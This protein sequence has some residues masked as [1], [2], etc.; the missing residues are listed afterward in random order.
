MVRRYR[1][2]AGV[3]EGIGPN[4]YL[5]SLALFR[6]LLSEYRKYAK[7][8]RCILDTMPNNLDRFAIHADDVSRARRFYEK[9]FGW[10]FEAWGPPDFYLVTTGTKKDPGVGGLLQKRQEP[11]TGT[12]LRAF[13]CTITVEDVNAIAKLVEQNGGKV[14]MPKAVI[15]TVGWII[16]FFDTEG[17]VV[18]AGQFDANAK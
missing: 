6:H 14:T 15:P 13:E 5:A 18:C 3:S 10:K 2:P 12:G 7:P 1:V 4:N 8:V 17:N 11:L 9:V 16:R